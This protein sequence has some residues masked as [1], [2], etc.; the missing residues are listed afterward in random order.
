VEP[1]GVGRYTAEAEATAYFCVLE[2]LQNAAK[3]AEASTAT[4]R[5]GGE[6]DHLVFSV[7]DDG[8]GFDP[9]TTPAGS[10]LQNMMDRVE[11]LGGSLVVESAPGRGTLVTGRI[12]TPPGA[13]PV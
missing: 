3:Y 10:G 2:A 12:P 4:V 13:A 1:N 9:A 6:D 8:R 11:A 7:T 5:L